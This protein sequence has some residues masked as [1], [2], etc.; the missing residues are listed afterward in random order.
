MWNKKRIAIVALAITIGLTLFVSF[1]YFNDED[2]TRT[3]SYSSPN[4]SVRLKNEAIDTTPQIM[5]V[6]SIQLYNKV[7]KQLDNHKEIDVIDHNG[8]DKSH[9]HHHQ[10][11]VDFK[12]H[13]TQAE[14]KQIEKDIEGKL[15]RKLDSSY[16]F[17]S[18]NLKTG[19]MISYFEKNKNV[20]F[21]EPNYIMM[22]NQEHPNDLLYNDFQWNLRM[23]D[24][25]NGWGITQGSDKVKIAIVDTG[26]DLDH[27]DLVN[28]I[29]EGYNIL[30]DNNV[31][32]DDN[33]HGTHVAGIIASQTNNHEGTAGITWFNPIMPVKVMGSDGYGSTFDIARGIIWAT[34]H[35]ADVINLS[36]GNYQGS[37]LLKQAVEYA[38][39]HDVVMVAASGN[40][41]S[42]Q[43]SYPSA[44]PQVLSVAAVDLNGD[45]AD[46]SNYGDYID[47]AAPGVTIPSTYI[48][49]QYAALSG[50]SMAAPHVAALAALMRSINPNLSNK[51]IMDMIKGTSL[52]LGKAGKDIYFGE[53]LIDIVQALQQA[54]QG[55]KAKSG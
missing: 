20:E 12:N 36:L 33:G 26:V 14:I 25:E 48:D 43:P 50:T 46:F 29:T 18:T 11:I 31:P 7:Q 27:P 15:L 40:D 4:S 13:L 30:K 45:K 22:Q 34:D 5:N 47:V 44:Y 51:E 23:I 52:D 17:E 37:K 28:R 39:K 53:G 19:E 3:R 9:Y 24:S 32:D 35:G 54:K 1:S 16:I 6:D 41:N 21:A 10:V 2:K 8:K 55:A 49:E 42:S 38:Y